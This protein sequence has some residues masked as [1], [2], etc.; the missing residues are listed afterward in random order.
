M[1]GAVSR[2][3]ISLALP[4]EPG[5]FPWGTF[6]VNVTG[7]FVLGFLLVVLLEQFPRGRLARS[8][9]GT[10][11]IGAYTTLSTFVV[12]AVE[13]VRDGH[14]DRCDGVSA[15]QP[16]GRTRRRVVRG[17]RH[18]TGDPRRALVRRGAP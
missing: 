6:L 9:I 11:F 14:P 3:A 2:Y 5:R 4:S 15:R 7:S 12:K 8:V 10:G 13:L 17:Q 1:L 16:G 18:A